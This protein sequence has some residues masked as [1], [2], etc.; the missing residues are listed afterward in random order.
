MNRRAFLLGAAGGAVAAMVPAVATAPVFGAPPVTS[1]MLADANALERLHRLIVEC[2]ERCMNPPLVIDDT[3]YSFIVEAG[4]VNRG[5]VV[6]HL[7]AD[8]WRHL[9][10]LLDQWTFARGDDT[11]LTGT[12]VLARQTLAFRPSEAP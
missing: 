5:F 12:E 9:E 2:A 1:A 11:T 8:D 4:G 10:W 6:S 3:G 7:P